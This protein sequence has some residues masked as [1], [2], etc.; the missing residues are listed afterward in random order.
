MSVYMYVYQNFTHVSLY[1]FDMSLNKY[2]YHIPNMSHKAIML[3]GY[4][5]SIFA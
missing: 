4:R 5:P 1:T 2:G 3:N